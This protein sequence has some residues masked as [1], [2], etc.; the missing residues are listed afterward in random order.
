[1]AF[2][3][4]LNNVQ[5]ADLFQTLAQNRQEGV[6]TLSSRGA[7]HR[8]AFRKEGVTLLDP[9]IGG[10]RRIGEILVSARLIEEKELAEALREQAKQRRF[11][12]EIL[13]EKGKVKQEDLDQILSL[14]VEEEIYELFRAEAGTF[15]FTE[16]DPAVLCVAAG[17][18]VRPLPVDQVVFE[19][20]RRLDEWSLIQRVIPSI[21]GV[22]VATVAVDGSIEDEQERAILG[23]LDGRHSVRDVADSLL[24]SPFYV[25][26]VLARTIELG[27]ARPAKIEELLVTAR[28]LL[29]ENQRNRA[30]RFLHR[31]DEII[32][33]PSPLDAQLAE[34]FKLAGD[35]KA[36][37]QTRVKLASAAR[38]ANKLDS[39]RHELEVALKEWPGSVSVL[40]TLSQVLKE[41]GDDEAELAVIRDLAAAQTDAGL[42]DAA[43]K[44][45]ERMI[46]LAPD[47]AD[48]RRRYADLC[49]RAHLK[50]KA[51]ELLEREAQRLK[52]DGQAGE[53]AAIYKRILSIDGGRKDVKRAL[54]G[55]RRSKT[56][57]VVR[58]AASIAILLALASLAGFVGLRYHSKTKGLARLKEAQVRVESGEF[59]EARAIVEEVLADEPRPDVAHDGMA[60]LD[61]IDRVIAENARTKRGAREDQLSVKLA[62]IQAQADRMEFDTALADCVELLRHE[63]EAYL[64]E[65]IRTRIQVIQQALLGLV[66]KA[67]EQSQGFRQPERDEDVGPTY[68]A[69]SDAFPLALATALPRVRD[70]AFVAA[71]ELEGEPREWMHQILSAADAYDLMQAKMRP[72]LEAL[73]TRHVRLQTLQQLSAEYLEAARAAEAGNVERSRELLRKVIEDYERTGGGQL[74]GVL[75]QRLKRLDVAAEAVQEVERRLARG[76]YDV[77]YSVAHKAAEDFRDLQIPSTLALP[78]LIDSLPRGARVRQGGKEGGTTPLVVRVQL[79]SKVG[80]ELELAGR[81]PQSLEVDA[82]GGGRHL[83][84]MAR[85]SLAAGR[86]D[87]T[88]HSAPLPADGRFYVAGRDGT[89][90]S[91]ERARTKGDPPAVRTFRTGSLSGSLGAPLAVPGGF[92]ATVFEGKVFRVDASGAEL[93]AKWTRSLDAEIKVGPLLHGDLV[94][95][96]TEGSRV[97][98]LAVEDGAVRW[99]IPLE[100]KRVVGAPVLLQGRLFVPLAGGM[101]SVISLATAKVEFEQPVGEEIVEGLVTD[102]EELVT[103]TSTGRL[104][105]LDPVTAAVR[106]RVDLGDVAIDLPRVGGG[107]ADVP[108]GKRVVRI[109]FDSL[110]I[111][112]DWSGLSPGA[113]PASIDG[114]LWVPCEKGTIEVI[115]PKQGIVVERARLGS[116]GFAGAPIA[117]PDAVFLLSRDGSFALLAR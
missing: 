104:L 79:G 93:T 14:Q 69:M 55:L 80:I 38:A 7:T 46:E 4:D 95:V 111:T 116:G 29:A 54:A 115:D 15:E 34:L 3:G 98:A 77:A 67:K 18:S 39:A 83:V 73:R 85:V 43:L 51:I 101:I 94:L 36:A 28:D 91:I 84:E 81:A 31:L 65:R 117:T 49:L 27:R 6:L 8:I 113:T 61:Q 75:E 10:R 12:G 45:M 78:V 56:D 47:D 92:V 57:R 109:P 19:A 35:L 11:L 87:G 32:P 13:V 106:G 74:S 23:H 1:V 16:G 58:L 59:A 66:A 26:K 71:K 44:S 30:L 24:S 99:Q 68:T 64:A 5:L 63:P 20:A 107:V 90:H 9:A 108:L 76:E 86:L 42:V 114:L 53:L 97:V 40:H 70:V 88:A 72:A 48:A 62:A 82:D 112:G 2:K 110:T 50:D 89:F 41:L 103:T 22:Y 102:G 25:A 33:D 105:R 52:K 37:A 96:V 100:G 21:D 60:L 17:P